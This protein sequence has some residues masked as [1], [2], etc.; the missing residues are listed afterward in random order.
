[1]ESTFLILPV[2]NR[3]WKIKWNPLCSS[4]GHLITL[5]VNENS[6]EIEKEVRYLLVIIVD[7]YFSSILWLSIGHFHTFVTFDKK[8]WFISIDSKVISEYDNF[9]CL[10]WPSHKT[11][12]EKMCAF[13]LRA[14]KI[15][16]ICCTGFMATRKKMVFEFSESNCIMNKNYCLEK[17]NIKD[18]FFFFSFFFFWLITC[19]RLNVTSPYSQ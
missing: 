1:M 17:Q 8:V 2:V 18:V 14:V 10:K 12:L 4:E 9:I 16:R 15:R 3:K 7:H 5:C 13:W 6:N 19:G 11:A